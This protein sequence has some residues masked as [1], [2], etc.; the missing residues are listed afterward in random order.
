MPC[1]IT[2]PAFFTRLSFVL[3]FGLAIFSSPPIHLARAADPPE[4]DAAAYAPRPL[5]FAE[6]NLSYPM[7]VG[8]LDKKA[9]QEQWFVAVVSL[10]GAGLNSKNTRNSR[11]KTDK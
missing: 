5:K 2:S 1:P 3:V 4:D 6:S 7:S 9:A 10:E 11:F 8:S